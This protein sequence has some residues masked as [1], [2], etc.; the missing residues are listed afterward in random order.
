MELD[1]TLETGCLRRSLGLPQR[2]A[3]R[4]REVGCNGGVGLLDG[5]PARMPIIA[6]RLWLRLSPS[7]KLPPLAD[8]KVAESCRGT[9]ASVSAPWRTP[10]NP[11]RRN[12]S[13]RLRLTGSGLVLTD[14]GDRMRAGLSWEELGRSGCGARPKFNP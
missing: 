9:K 4:A 13:T 10:V 2:G 8:T 1:G 6:G 7:N 14:L 11:R 12:L 3:G 5:F